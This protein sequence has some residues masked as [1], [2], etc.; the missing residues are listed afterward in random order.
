MEVILISECP[1]SEVPQDI[2]VHFQTDTIC[3]NLFHF[4]LSP[5]NSTTS[6]VEYFT[7]KLINPQKDLDCLRSQ[8]TPI[9]D[10]IVLDLESASKLSYSEGISPTLLSSI[11]NP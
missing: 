1:L 5:E 8:T 4:R 2:I 10:G 6:D 9:G 7:D 3:K 11:I